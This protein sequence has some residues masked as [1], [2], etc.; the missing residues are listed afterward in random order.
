M[1]IVFYGIGMLGGAALAAWQ[2]FE[3]AP[4]PLIFAFGVIVA[5]MFGIAIS[6]E[7]G[8]NETVV[9]HTIEHVD[10]P[11]GGGAEIRPLPRRPGA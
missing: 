8:E 3:F 4:S 6:D 10:P 7:H 9:R 2:L 11:E 5:I 1:K